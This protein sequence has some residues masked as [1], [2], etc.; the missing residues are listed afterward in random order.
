MEIDQTSEED[1]SFTPVVD[2][3]FYVFNGVSTTKSISSYSQQVQS[4]GLNESSSSEENNEENKED[5]KDQNNEDTKEDRK[6]FNDEDSS[7]SIYLSPPPASNKIPCEICEELVD[8]NDYSSHLATHLS[9][10]VPDISCKCPACRKKARTRKKTASKFTFKPPLPT[11]T[12]PS[13]VPIKTEQQQP[14]LNFIIPCDACGALIP[15][16]KYQE[17]IDLHL[18]PPSVEKPTKADQLTRCAYS[19]AGIIK[20]CHICLMDYKMKETIVYLPCTH[21][22]HEKCITVWMKNSNLCPVCMKEILKIE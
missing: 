2:P 20:E 18:K 17:H 10:N 1:S 4:N 21:F 15:I 12:Q 11:K 19:G 6:I 3:P 8:F 14:S 16:N 7:S 13:S 22:Y 9:S 5:N